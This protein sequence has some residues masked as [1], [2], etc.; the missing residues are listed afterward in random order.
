VADEEVLLL[1]DVA[2]YRLVELVACDAQALG[3]DDAAQA[4][5]RD[6]GSAATDVDDHAAR[7]LGD[8]DA[9]AYRCCQRLLD[10]ERL[11]SAHLT[12]RLQ[13]RAPLDLGHA[14]RHADHHLRLEQ[15]AWP[16]EHL[17]HEGLQHLL[18]EVVIRD[19]AVPHGPDGDDVARG[20]PQHAVRLL[21]DGLHLAGVAHHG[22]DR[23][24]PQEDA[25]AFHVD[26][27]R[28]RAQVDPDLLSQSEEHAQLPP[29]RDSAAV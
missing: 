24:L 15:P 11:A 28:G 23:G 16:P 27:D 19:D 3:H 18:G 1:A 26:Q 12:G 5:Y 22:Y 8:L 25:L 17:A 13:H 2:D 29:W 7:W 14:R 20:A 21:A 4:D 6:V 9:G 10:E